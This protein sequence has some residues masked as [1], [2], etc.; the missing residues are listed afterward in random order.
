[1]RPTPS[2]SLDVVEM[3]CGSSAEVAPAPVVV[4]PGSE[5]LGPD[6]RA[7][8]LGLPESGPAPRRAREP[9]LG[10]LGVEPP[11]RL[12]GPLGVSGPAPRRVRATVRADTLGVGAPPRAL[13]G[14]SSSSSARVSA[15]GEPRP[16]RARAGSRS[17]TLQAWRGRPMAPGRLPRS[18]GSLMPS[19]SFPSVPTRSAATSADRM[20]APARARAG[21]R[22]ST[23][24]AWRGHRSPT[25]CAPGLRELA[26]G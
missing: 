11:E 26:P 10:V 15:D 13:L 20:T 17:S 1:M 8:D 12:S 23:L 24:R 7:G 21:C 16:I 5:L 25:G 18:S 3:L 2:E 9:W 22:S 14:S 6:A 19:T 4:P